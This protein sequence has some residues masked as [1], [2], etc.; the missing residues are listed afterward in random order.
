MNEDIR[1]SFGLSWMGR[2]V[3]RWGLVE[4][5]SRRVE[6]PAHFFSTVETSEGEGVTKWREGRYFDEELLCDVDTR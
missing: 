6:R 4:L 1:V 2:I 5:R 3:R